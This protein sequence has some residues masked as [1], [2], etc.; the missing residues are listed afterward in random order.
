MRLE[1]FLSSDRIFGIGLVA[2]VLDAGGQGQTLL[3]EGGRQ[4]LENAPPLSYTSTRIDGRRRELAGIEGER[5]FAE[6][7]L[8][9]PARSQVNPDAARGLPDACADFE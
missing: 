8:P 7:G 3:H 1:F 5:E 9:R 4:F 2:R 6:Q